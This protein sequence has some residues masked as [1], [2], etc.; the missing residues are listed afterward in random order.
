MATGAVEHIFIDRQLQKVLYDYAVA[1]KLVSKRDLKTW[2][3]YPRPTG[4]ANAIVK[5]VKGHV[6]HIHIRFGCPAEMKR[7]RSK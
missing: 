2:L 7:C 3:E 6:D 4:S 1:E 5:H